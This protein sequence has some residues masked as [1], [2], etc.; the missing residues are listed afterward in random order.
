MDMGIEF[1]P[2]V[3]GALLVVTVGFWIANHF[4]QLLRKKMLATNMDPSLRPFLLSLLS[5]LLKVMIVFSAAGIVGIQTTSFVAVL[6]AAGLAIGL[7]LQGSLSNFASGILIL[8]F[9]PYKVGDIILAQGYTGTIREIQIFTTILSTIDNR[10]VIIP[11]AA[12]LSGPIEN[13]SGYPER[14]V[15]VVVGIRYS[16]DIDKAKAIIAEVIPNMPG[17][18]PDK[19]VRIFVKQLGNHSVDIGVRFWVVGTEF[20]NASFLFYEHAKKAF[21][22]EGVGIP[23]PQMDVWLRQV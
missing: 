19:D 6:G 10:M 4:T 18:V 15:D 9:R 21:D 11:N 23:F 8:L 7:A 3:A 16:D 12:M 5:A 14:Q 17:L 1:A 13:F 22:R 20:L 2:R